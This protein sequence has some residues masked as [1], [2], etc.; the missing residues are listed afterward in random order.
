[1][2]NNNKSKQ[3]SSAASTPPQTLYK[4]FA[5]S[6]QTRKNADEQTKYL[7][8]K[9]LDA[10]VHPTVISGK[11]WYRVQTGAFSSEVKA[12]AY[13]SQLKKLG[14]T[15]SFLVVEKAA[16][17]SSPTAGSTTPAK[18]ESSK[19]NTATPAKSPS[20][21]KSPTSSKPAPKPGSNTQTSGNT[22]GQGSTKPAAG[23]S[24]AGQTPTTTTPTSGTGNA[25]AGVTPPD[26]STIMGATFLSPLQMNQFVKSINPAAVELGDFYYKYGNYYG[27]R[28][29]VAFAQSLLETNYFRFTGVVKASQNNF[30]GLGATGQTT[31]GAA[32]KTPEEGVLAQFQHLYAYATT[33]AM[34]SQYPLV[35]PRFHLV[36]RGTAVNWIDLNGKWAYPGDTY[37]QMILSIYE[38]MVQFATGAKI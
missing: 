10:F 14:I 28:G 2:E 1:M 3:N 12:Q 19:Q 33:K 22:T 18:N 31:G 13:M 15:G 30:S 26:P 7:K 25:A 32:F 23:T 37:G 36:N 16:A 8:S 11:K 20:T 4:V 9:G 27:I 34:P 17:P 38:R 6:F 35:D 24:G 21:S 5:G 29:D